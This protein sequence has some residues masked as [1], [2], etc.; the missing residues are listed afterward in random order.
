MDQAIKMAKKAYEEQEVP[1]GAAIYQGDRLIAVAH[2]LCKKNNSPTAH[3]EMIVIEQA[4]RSLQTTYLQ[5]CELYVT[6]EPC[7]MCMGAILAARLSRLVYGA[8]E[9]QSGFVESTVHIQTLAN[10][11]NIEIYSGIREEECAKLMQRF[12]YEARNRDGKITL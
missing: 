2:N 6:I 5:G 1:V 9:P 4:L 8:I 10:T 3:A 11:K 12:F 7:M